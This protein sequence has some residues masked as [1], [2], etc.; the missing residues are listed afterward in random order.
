MMPGEHIPACLIETIETLETLAE[1]LGL[2]Q[3]FSLCPYKTR[4]ASQCIGGGETLA[5]MR[6]GEV[7]RRIARG[8]NFLIG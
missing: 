8:R 7:K 4:H 2:S 3:A 1:R 6:N 5:G